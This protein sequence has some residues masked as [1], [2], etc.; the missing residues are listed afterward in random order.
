MRRH[1]HRP[2]SAMRAVVRLSGRP[3]MRRALAMMLLCVGSTFPTLCSAAGGTLV[4]RAAVPTGCCNKVVGQYE[5]V[6][7]DYAQDPASQQAAWDTWV[8]NYGFDPADFLNN[9]SMVYN[10]ASY[11][12]GPTT[13]YWHQPV[14]R[15]V[16]DGNKSGCWTPDPDG[17]I[18]YGCGHVCWVTDVRGKC[19]SGFVCKN[20]QHMYPGINVTANRRSQ[21]P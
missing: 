4:L 1:I 3:R 5:F 19:G 8:D 13:I 10:C 18:Y 15:Y 20:N 21:V 16:S 7:Q 12:F 2:E 9:R 6:G 17:P 14:D 11:V